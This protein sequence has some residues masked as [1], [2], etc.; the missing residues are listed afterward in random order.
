MPRTAAPLLTSP[1]PR[2]ADRD[3]RRTNASVVVRSV[4]EHGP[5]ARST[6]ARLTGLSLVS[7]TDFCARFAELGLI[8][9]ADA[10]RRSNGVGR[11]HVHMEQ[12][13][14][15]GG[16][17]KRPF[18]HAHGASRIAS[19]RQPL[20][21]GGTWSL[22][23]PAGGEVSA[24][25]VV[26]IRG[27]SISMARQPSDESPISDEEWEKFLRDTEREALDSAPKEPSARARMVTARLRQ[28]EERGELPDGWRTGP[29]SQEMNG[30]ATR[31]RRMWAIIGIPV[32]IAVVLVAVKP[33]LL[34]GDPLGSG[35][36]DDPVAA[37]ALPAETGRPTAPPSTMAP[38]T[39]TLADP[40]AGSPAKRYADG[41]AGIVPPKA[42]AV[43]VFSKAQVGEALRQTRELLVDANL[44]PATLRGAR[45]EAALGVIEPRQT[46]LVEL[47]DTSLSKP[48]ER[49]D[50][51]TMFSRFDP[52]ETRL[53]GD[54]VKTRGRMTFEAGKDG[55]VVVH[56]DYTFVYPLVK[57]RDGATEVARTVVRRLL[58]VQLYDPNRYRVTPG[59]ISVRHYDQDVGNSACDINDGFFHPQFASDAPTGPTPSGSAVDPYD[60]SRTLDPNRVDGC[61]TVTRI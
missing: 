56:A 3:R 16:G 46:E 31:R 49:H 60:R 7:V 4:L 41:A 30:R 18:G 42:T 57:T 11:P 15:A 29:A 34:P 36:S 23:G 32:A 28:Q 21:G 26:C 40:F 45:P 5:V 51:L 52:D 54:V 10:P 9:G 19:V 24:G 35:P 38:G 39:P 58:D 25:P 48:D 55:S 6:I 2:A 17:G 43:G 33:S 44:D 22:G 14:S 59:K 53:V 12:P 8:R 20:P 37:S 47:L 50:P 13:T 61:G 27:G 1:A